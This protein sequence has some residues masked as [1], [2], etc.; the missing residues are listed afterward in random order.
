LVPFSIPLP[1]LVIPRHVLEA[2]FDVPMRNPFLVF[3]VVAHLHGSSVQASS[4]DVTCGTVEKVA[5]TVLM[6]RT[7]FAP[8]KIK[9]EEELSAAQFPIVPS[10][11]NGTTSNA[12]GDVTGGLR[13]N[14]TRQQPDM[15]RSLTSMGLDWNQSNFTEL[16]DAGFVSPAHTECFRWDKD[17]GNKDKGACDP[18][19]VLELHCSEK[20]IASA[21]GEKLLH[22][23]TIASTV[24][25]NS[26]L[27]CQE[28]CQNLEGCMYFTFD[29]NEGLYKSACWLKSNITCKPLYA[30]SPGVVSGPASCSTDESGS[31]LLAMPSASLAPKVGFHMDSDVDRQI[32]ATMKHEGAPA[33][34]SKKKP[35]NPQ[36]NTTM[37]HK[38]SPPG[39]SKK[40]PLNPQTN[41]TMKHKGSPPSTST[42]KPL[43]PQIPTTMKDKGALPSASKK[44]VQAFKDNWASPP[45]TS[46]KK[47]LNPQIPTT[48]KDKG[49]LPSASKKNVQA[50]KDNWASPPSTSTKKPLNPQIHAT[51]KDK[52]TLPS[53]SKKNVQALKTNRDGGSVSSEVT[54][55]TI[56][57][58]TRNSQTPKKKK[59]SSLKAGA[60][61]TL[62]SQNITLSNTTGNAQTP[63]R[64]KSNTVKASAA[65]TLGSQN[66][67]VPSKEV[68]NSAEARSSD[69]TEAKQQS[70]SWSAWLWHN[71]F[72]WP[73]LT[74]TSCLIVFAYSHNAEK[75][76]VAMES[77][78]D[79]EGPHASNRQQALQR[80]NR[81]SRPSGPPIS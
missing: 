30:N 12:N 36:T 33:S 8:P 52:G 53:A 19:D 15:Q 70:Q 46:T 72:G 34:T 64:T 1:V 77:Q 71:A 18:A 35:L 3:I 27:Q 24:S 59:S 58:T 25:Y 73:T 39:T 10:S 78:M 48:M 41:T 42:K 74:L 79:G 28:A 45:S 55:R 26:A 4:G 50:F 68:Q 54:P 13:V 66:I 57:N 9:I 17:Y 47:P 14:T 56:S 75:R 38:G 11:H 29:T 49:A 80:Q 32:D 65:G 40:K 16:E 81:W 7:A 67:T 21:T 23:E 44:N 61:G 6:Q 51:M 76:D 5:G 63:K 69:S 60:N 20:C 37:K 31:H 62:D 22:K 43:N 2:A